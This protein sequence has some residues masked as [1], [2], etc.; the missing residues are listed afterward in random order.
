M[1]S[2]AELK[3]LYY[4]SVYIFIH[5][6]IYYFLNLL[7]LANKTIIKRIFLPWRNKRYAVLIHSAALQP[8]RSL[9]NH[10]LN[11]TIRMKYFYSFSR[12]SP[13][14]FEVGAPDGMLFLHPSSVFKIRSFVNRKTGQ[15]TDKQP[16]AYK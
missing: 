10:C 4:L 11:W 7:G 9:T 15:S 8:I 5:S 13:T 16:N 12:L 2:V 14:R 6:Y 3:L 1:L